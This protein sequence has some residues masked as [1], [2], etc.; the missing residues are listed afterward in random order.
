MSFWQKSLDRFHFLW[1]I[2][3][4]KTYVRTKPMDLI[5]EHCSL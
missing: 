4:E 1:G 5:Q 3:V 2:T